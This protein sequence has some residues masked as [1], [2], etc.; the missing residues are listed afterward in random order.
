MFNNHLDAGS[1]SWNTE[2]PHW[3]EATCILIKRV[4]SY[5]GGNRR[6]CI[7]IWNQCKSFRKAL[8]ELGC[9]IKNILPRAWD[10]GKIPNSSYCNFR[11]MTV[12]QLSEG[13]KVLSVSNWVTVWVLLLLLLGFFKFLCFLIASDSPVCS[14]CY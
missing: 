13:K 12:N 1:G 9:K 10:L 8:R 4:A 14:G 11:I 2:E 5:L 6:I 3:R 7:E